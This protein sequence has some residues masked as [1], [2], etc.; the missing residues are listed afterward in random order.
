MESNPPASRFA[1]DAEFAEFLEELRP[2]IQ[3]LL[4]RYRIPALEAEDLVQQAL[5]AMLYK[6]DRIRNREA[7]LLGAVKNKCRLY[8][9]SESRRVCDAVDLALLE[10]LSGAEPPSQERVGLRRDLEGLI[11]QL[12]DRCRNLLRLRFGLGYESEEV[13]QALGYRPSSVRKVTNRCISALAQGLRQAAVGTQ[14]RTPKNRYP[15]HRA[16]MT[17]GPQAATA[18]GRTPVSPN[19]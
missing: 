7:W 10:W 13:A 18:G 15:D 8:W 12:P 4:H 2:R 5:L 17:L 6:E 9:R 3:Y 11:G 14:V 1:S 19:S 16:K